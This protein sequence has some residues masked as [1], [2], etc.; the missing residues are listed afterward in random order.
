L[1]EG[2]TV[3]LDVGKTLTKL[4]LWARGGV[5]IAREAR[6]NQRIDAGHYAAL[7]AEGIE[8]WTAQVLRDFAGR[9]RIA[10]IVPVAHG[11]AVAVLREGRLACAP[12]DYE[13]PPP[14]AV[15]ATYEPSRD[16]FAQTGSPL[17]PDGLNAGIQ[18]EWLAH[19]HPGLL[20]PGAVIVTW[21]QYW[22]WRFSG[23]AAT[24]VTS[25]G[26]H[27]DLWRPCEDRP[28]EL[29]ISRGWAELLAPLR[30]ADEV[31][32]KVTSEWVERAGL[33][34]DVSVY[35]GLHDSNAALLAARGFGE[36]SACESTVLSTGTWFVAMRSPARRTDVDIAALAEGRDCLVNVDAYGLPVPSARFMGGREV[37]ILS[38]IDTRR[39]D[40]KPD[41]PALLDATP[42]VVAKG[43]MALPTFTAGVGPFP[44]GHGR[45]LGMPQ[46]HYSRRAAVCLYAAL[47]A[48]TSLG[49]IGA[50]DR[51]LVEGR[52][53][54]AEVFVRALASLR[55]EDTLYVS[56]AQH[57]VS[58]GALRLIDPQLR[59]PS[60]LER[61]QPLDVDLTD[62]AREWRRHA[63]RI[64]AAA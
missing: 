16:S 8:A 49:L 31:L 40:I 45:W 35:C 47:V 2:L 48:D 10:A 51:I 6:P 1:K 27:T 13:E 58:Y 63:A 42:D 25:L 34:A 23:V 30:R 50:R 38:G 64:E 55:P 12:P 3:V 57:D 29:A 32:G 4:S 18:L 21:P 17:L 60:A 37:E 14:A 20:S 9:G 46:D 59:A 43:A 22:A 33:P 44:D 24:E 62:Y 52:F 56:N 5:L 11:A 54:E 19:L 26:C 36:I 41:Q 28:S 53:A 7:D 61:V 39:I 15:R